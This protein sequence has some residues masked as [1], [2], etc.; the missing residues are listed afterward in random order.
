M[1]E[2]SKRTPPSEERFSSV[3]AVMDTPSTSGAPEISV[4]VG[5]DE[6]SDL[7]A[8][9]RTRASVGGGGRNAVKGEAAS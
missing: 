7:V 1:P 6:R 9:V 3:D 2:S 5:P 4:C 8:T